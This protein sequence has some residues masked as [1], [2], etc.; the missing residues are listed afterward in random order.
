MSIYAVFLNDPDD[1]AWARV[2][3]HWNGASTY[4]RIIWP[5]SHRKK[6]PSPRKLRIRSESTGMGE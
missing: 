4:C 5:S 2:N 1:E 6:P 3:E